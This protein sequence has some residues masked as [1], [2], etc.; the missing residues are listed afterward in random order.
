MHADVDGR[1]FADEEVVSLLGTIINGGV[2]TDD[3]AVRRTRSS[4]STATTIVRDRLIAQP[5]LIPTATE[6]FLRY[7]SPVQAFARTVAQRHRARRPA[8]RRGDRVLMC[9]A[10]ANRDDR[11]FPDA[12]EFLPDR[13]P[14]RHVAFG[15]G[16]HRCIGSTLARAEFA[17]M[18]ETTLRRIPDFRIVRSATVR[19]P[20]L[21]I[22]NGYVS[23]PARF[24]PAARVASS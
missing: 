8:L 14:N 16:K 21:G 20:S 13:Q 9:F 23:M 7:F 10:S 11:E 3:R 22:V 1:T 12:D 4:T 24:T 5:E 15:I 2:D 19:Y 18:L 6:E 17:T